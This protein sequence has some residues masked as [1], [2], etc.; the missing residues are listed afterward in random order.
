MPHRVISRRNWLELTALTTVATLVPRHDSAG[1]TTAPSLRETRIRRIVRE[2]EEQGFHRTGTSV[3]RASANWLRDLAHQSGLTASLESFSLHRVDPVSAALIVAGR[4]IEGIP[5][6]DAAFTNE[7]GVAGRLGLLDSDAEIGLAE[8]RPNA[9]GAGPLGDARR[10]NRHRAIVCVTRGGE[11]GLCPSN[12]ESF[13]EPFGPPVLQV[14][15]ELASWLQEQAQRGAEVRLVAH[16]KRTPA[17][18]FN[19]IAKISGD[20]PALPPLV[21]MTPRSGWYRCASERGGGLACWLELMPALRQAKPARDVVFVASSG[22]EL[23]Y[24][25]INAFIERR[26]GIVSNSVGWIHLGGNIGAAARPQAGGNTVQA[27][28]DEIERLLAQAMTSTALTIDVRVPHNRV[29]G[30]EAEVVHR[31]GGRYVSVIVSNIM[32]HNPMDRG[33]R[34]IDARAIGAFVEAFGM[35]AKTLA[36]REPFRS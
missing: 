25:G 4:R 31:G 23:G 29:P 20:N 15:S 6:F 24:L 3:D 9:A 12:A 2:F 27:S 8:S 17:E 32:F 36:G 5:L 35:V 10:A 13:L 19:V 28:D 22:H 14:G 1:Q 18:A 30:G 26:P 11:A 16:V 7:R 33:P 34:V 21:I